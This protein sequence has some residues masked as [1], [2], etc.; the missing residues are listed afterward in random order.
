MRLEIDTV[1]YGRAGPWA[2]NLWMKAPTSSSPGGMGRPGQGY[3]YLF[4]HAAAAALTASG[5]QDAVSTVFTRNQVGG[6]RCPQVHLY[7][8]GPGTDL[9]GIV[10]AVVKDGNDGDRPL[11]LDSD[12]SVADNTR[13]RPGRVPANVT[14][15][16]WH[17]I[18]LTTRPDGSRGYQLYVDGKLGAELPL[19]N[20]LAAGSEVDGGDPIQLTGPI[21][22]CG[23]ADGDPNRGFP[24]WLS[25]L[26]VFDIALTPDD[27]AAMYN[28]VLGPEDSFSYG[29]AVQ[30]LASPSPSPSSSALTSLLQTLTNTSLSITQFSDTMRVTVPTLFDTT[31]LFWPRVPA[32]FTVPS[33]TST[34]SL[35]SKFKFKF[36]DQA[37]PEVPPASYEV[38]EGG[39]CSLDLAQ[40][41]GLAFCAPGLVGDSAAGA[42]VRVDG[43]AGGGGGGPVGT[44]GMAAYPHPG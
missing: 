10:R 41:V 27:V 8:P 44:V 23:R 1:P 3:Q 15:G 31:G 9:Y 26:M 16:G 12:G 17:M 6:V 22:L 33:N 2:V 7:I 18:S 14:D 40:P 4:S 42:A 5:T 36:E 29:S 21:S 24:G 38:S 20:V 43:K 37:G 30:A 11:Y 28:V 25:Q 34:S 32:G 13:A 39:V 19:A 35:N